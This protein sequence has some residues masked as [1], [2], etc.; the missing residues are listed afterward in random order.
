MCRPE[1]VPRKLPPPHGT[2]DPVNP[3]LEGFHAILVPGGFG[4]RGTEGKIK[5][6][7][8]ARERKIP[9]M[10]ICLGIANQAILRGP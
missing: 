10:G 8:F 7:Q 4:E 5:A 3:H 9:Y 1:E 2:A 6:A